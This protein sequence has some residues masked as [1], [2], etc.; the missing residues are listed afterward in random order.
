MFRM[1]STSYKELARPVDWVGLLRMLGATAAGAVFAL[2]SVHHRVPPW[3]LAIML[4][5]VWVP[6]LERRHP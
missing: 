3:L 1:N 5:C 6:K 4:L 2:L